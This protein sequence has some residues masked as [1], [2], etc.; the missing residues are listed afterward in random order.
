MA[1]NTGQNFWVSSFP[2]TM[3]GG[4][5]YGGGGGYGTDSLTARDPLDAK[6][7]AAGF[8][9]GASYPDG[10][11]S[12]SRTDR[13]EG[14]LAID[15]NRLG[16]GSYQ[17]GVHKGDK[18]GNDAY[19]WDDNMNPD[20]GLQRQARSVPVN[21]EGATVLQSQRFAPTGDVPTHLV[22]GGRLQNPGAPES[23]D[24]VRAARMKPMLPP[25]SRA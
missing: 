18:V 8:A 21:Q 24:P 9:P 19:F 6:R 17:R 16:P 22:A 3:P 13:Q 20:M 2:A 5:V 14:K 1:G 23:I 10:Y 12:T 11:L 25:W 15:A 7:I 4:T